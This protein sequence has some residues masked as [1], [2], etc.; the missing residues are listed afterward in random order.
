MQGGGGGQQ[1]VSLSTSQNGKGGHEMRGLA[2]VRVLSEV[3]GKVSLRCDKI[4]SFSPLSCRDL[5][6]AM[7]LLEGV[8]EGG[9]SVSLEKHSCFPF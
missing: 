8:L 6:R 5:E 7:L 2:N 9:F 3:E 1:I 4:S